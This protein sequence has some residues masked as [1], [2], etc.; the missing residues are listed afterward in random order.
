MIIIFSHIRRVKNRVNFNLF[1]FVLIINYNNKR[2]SW[3]GF[4]PHILPSIYAH[5]PT[6]I[7]IEVCNFPCTFLNNEGN[8]GKNVGNNIFLSEYLP[9]NSK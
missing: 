3:G 6:I 2:R 9:N 8:P 7:N 5:A 4:I 1:Y